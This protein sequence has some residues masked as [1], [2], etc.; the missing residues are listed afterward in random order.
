[1]VMTVNAFISVTFAADGTWD[2][3]VSTAQAYSTQSVRYFWKW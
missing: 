3:R 2:I 1:M